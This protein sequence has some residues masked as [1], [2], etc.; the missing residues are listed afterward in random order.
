MKVHRVA[1]VLLLVAASACGGEDDAGSAGDTWV[2]TITT[3]GNVTTVVNESGSVWGGTASLVEEASI[4]VAVGPEEYMLGEIAAVYAT[5]DEIYLLDESVSK[6]RVYDLAGAHLRSF[7]GPGQGPGELG[8]RARWLLVGDDGRVFVG[9]LRN[10]RI[11]VFS[12]EGEALDSLPL[13]ARSTSGLAPMVFADNGG[14]WWTVRVPGEDGSPTRTGLQVLTTEGLVGD[15]LF[16]P[17]IE[18]E[19]L[20]IRTGGREGLPVPFS[21]A[22]PWTFGYRQV[23]ITGASDRYTFRMIRPTGETTFVERHG[24]PVP[25]SSE[26][27]DYWRRYSLAGFRGQEVTWNGENIPEH[28]P[29]F[30]QFLPAT[31]G[32]IWVLRHGAGDLDECALEPEDA[33]AAGFSQEAIAC[34]YPNLFF[35]VFDPDGRYLGDVQGLQLNNTL[36]FISGSTVVAPFEDEAGTIMVKRYRLVPPREEYR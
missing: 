36:P 18:Y 9:D 32:E 25:V 30:I 3:E 12:R 28:K 1:L 4:G 34:L 29:A 21:P 20:F 23:L 24:E 15:P 33:M 2:G 31:T 6:V 17:Q 10:Q 35:D 13:P 5:D 27:A 26:E 22:A 8:A 11:N 7:G 14:I 19:R 16:L